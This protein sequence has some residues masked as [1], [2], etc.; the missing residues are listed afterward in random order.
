MVDNF[1]ALFNC[2]PVD[3]ASDSILAP[4]L[5]YSFKLVGTEAIVCCLV[6]RVS[7]D[8]LLLLQITS[9]VVWHTRD[10]HLLHNA[11]YLL[12]P[13]ICFFIVL[14]RDLF[15]YRDDSMTGYHANRTTN[16]FFVP[17]QKLRA[18]LAP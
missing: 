18:R 7:T 10:L 17:L 16:L 4:A 2:T 15:D 13:G 3:R 14:K 5:S 8:D 12:N 6:H 9:G 11:L 1:A